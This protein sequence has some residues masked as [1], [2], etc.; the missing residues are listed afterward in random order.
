MA[1]P[2]GNDLIGD[3]L[4][5]ATATLA[6]RG[7]GRLTGDA[8]VPPPQSRRAW[9]G[10]SLIG[11]WTPNRAEVAS[12]AASAA[13]AEKIS[14]TDADLVIV[15]MGKPLQEDWIDAYGE[16]TGA[17]VLLAFD[18]VVDFLA[19][20]VSRAPR[21]W[22][23]RDREDV[24]AH[25]GAPVLAKRY[26]VEGPP[27]YLAVADLRVIKKHEPL[28]ARGAA[29]PPLSRPCPPGG[30]RPAP[31]ARSA[32]SHHV[33]LAGTHRL[34][35]GVGAAHAATPAAGRDCESGYGAPNAPRLPAAASRIDNTRSPEVPLVRKPGSR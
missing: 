8:R 7:R 3:I 4:R 22:R 10:V 28:P 35:D 25:A 13:I 14:H 30:S 17:R 32:P 33:D 24:A 6:R 15:F 31:S 19:G 26:L 5:R 20:R 2:A 12:S 21:G 16:A 1:A 29:G 23:A 9:P 27:A 34:A 18:A 11:H